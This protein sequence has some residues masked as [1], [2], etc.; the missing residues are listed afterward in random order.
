ML[1]KI[2]IANRG[3]I[4]IRI[5]R[6]CRELDIRTVAIYSE[7]DKD[8]LHT[9]MADEAICVGGPLTK[10]SYLNVTNILSACVLT[11]CEGI[12]PGFGFLS[13]NPKFAKMC[14][15]CNIKF[16]GP[17][18]E[19]IELMGDKA[20]A[21]KIMKKA[22]VPV[23]PGY[24]GEINSYE[25]ALKISNEIGYPLMIKA[26][27]GGGGKGIRIV[28]EPGEFKHN[29]EAAKL[30]SK[31]CFG[32][33]KLYIEKYIECPR[34]IEFQILADEYGNIIHLGERECSLQR[35]NQKVLEEAP[36]CF[37]DKSLRNEM[38][39]VAVRAAKAVNYKNA[40]TIEFLVD[41]N[42]HFYFMEMNT[43]IQVEHP[44]T[45]MITN[46][47]IVKEQLKIAS[48][49]KLDITQEDVKINGHAIECRINA[50][51]PSNNFRPCPGVINELYVPSGPGVRVDSAIYC[52]YEIPPYYDSM[53]GKLITF[54]DDRE[55]AI[56][57]MKRA[58]DE[59]AIGG[60]IT[61]IDFQYEI[62][63]HEDFINGDYN[64]SF[65]ETKLVNNNA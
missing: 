8:A 60:V 10:D 53:I 34:H 45:E 57:K 12:H 33:D 17:D 61:N 62:L 14:E 26:A 63:E 4:A 32:E 16:I 52:G 29:Y 13:E 31:A 30:E 44:I 6:A 48:N 25:H 51:D 58:L 15:E 1:K 27:A 64:T 37:L 11:G 54:G 19:V 56:I 18:F 59:F 41:K 46:I 47:D 50:E 9:Q 38:G 24:E 35:N 21:R 55:N 23:V 5:I 42:G 7:G 2:L 39:K 3:E 49:M 40:G 28:R 20:K 43:R 22:N 65:I 36:S